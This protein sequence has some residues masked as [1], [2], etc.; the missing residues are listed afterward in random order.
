MIRFTVDGPPVG[1][2]RPRRGKHGVWYTPR[3][4]LDYESKV[5][6][7]FLQAKQASAEECRGDRVQIKV[8]MA[9]A[10]RPDLDNILKAVVDGLQGVAYANDRTITAM[11]IR[12]VPTTGPSY[13]EVM[14]S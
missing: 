7:A 11:T 8:F 14:V 3:K 1:K 10:R 12:V 2:E 9:I 5:R 6:T 4:T 13:V